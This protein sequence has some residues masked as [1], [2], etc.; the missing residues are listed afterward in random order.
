MDDVAK[1][2]RRKKKE[3]K[4]GESML[5]NARQRRERKAEAE[6]SL[7]AGKRVMRITFFEPMVL[8]E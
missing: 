6:L 3:G 7:G 2:D 1:T 5:N 4:N 8:A